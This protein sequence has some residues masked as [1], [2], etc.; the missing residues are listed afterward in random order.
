MIGLA[1]ARRVWP[2]GSAEYQAA[3]E[4]R[5]VAQYRTDADNGLATR[6]VTRAGLNP[7]PPRAHGLW[8]SPR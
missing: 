4:A 3:V 8:R 7:D 1:V 2:E 6:K 5:R